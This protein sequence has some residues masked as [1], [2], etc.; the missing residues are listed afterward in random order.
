MQF[1]FGC[2]PMEVGACCKV[3][4]WTRVT[5]LVRL[6]RPVWGSLAICFLNF[7][8]FLHRRFVFRDFPRARTGLLCFLWLVL[9]EF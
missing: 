3:L 9:Q 6:G 7:W 1:Q 2:F 5:G 8:A 4:L